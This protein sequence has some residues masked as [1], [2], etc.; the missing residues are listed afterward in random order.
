MP[1]TA[2]ILRVCCHDHSSS[3]AFSQWHAK[4]EGHMGVYKKYDMIGWSRVC[5]EV[6]VCKYQEVIGGL[7]KQHQCICSRSEYNDL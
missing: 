7:W 6:G 1:P 5:G 3:D 4:G 2:G